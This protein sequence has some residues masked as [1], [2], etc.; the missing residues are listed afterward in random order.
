M[1]CHRFDP[2]I[3]VYRLRNNLNS[4]LKNSVLTVLSE[5]RLFTNGGMPYAVL[6]YAKHSEQNMPH[7]IGIGCTLC[8]IYKHRPLTQIERMNAFAVCGKAST[9]Y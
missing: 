9:V 7:S 8:C 6:V 3:S 5:N 2:R 1:F 4:A